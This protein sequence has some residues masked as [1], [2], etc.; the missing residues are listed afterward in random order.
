MTEF[1]TGDE[2][3]ISKEQNVSHLLGKDGP[4]IFDSYLNSTALIYVDTFEM[5]PYTLPVSFLRTKEEYEREKENGTI[6]VGSTA[7]INS[8]IP[9][10]E[11]EELY[12]L[13][14]RLYGKHCVI[15]RE[16]LNSNF[17]DDFFVLTEDNEFHY[18]P[19]K[20]L[21][22]IKLGENIVSD[23][24][25]EASD[26]INENRHNLTLDDVKEIVKNRDENAIFNI[27]DL[28]TVV[29]LV[30]FSTYG[31]NDVNDLNDLT[32]K[33]FGE[34]LTVV[35][36]SNS[37]D[38]EVSVSSVDGK[39]YN[40]PKKYIAHVAK[41]EQDTSKVINEEDSIET[42]STIK[43]DDIVYLSENI[44][45]IKSFVAQATVNAC[46]NKAL[47]VKKLPCEEND[48]MYNVKVGEM[49][50]N[51]KPIFITKENPNSKAVEQNVEYT[52]VP[53]SEVILVTVDGKEGFLIKK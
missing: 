1:N 15:V 33:L 27:G 5:E 19:K 30:P 53:K 22:G 24:A 18:I 37:G 25:K 42:V 52:F 29:E 45:N 26:G 3:W 47:I 23:E 39:I 46:G 21:V 6:H 49:Y 34:F 31:S 36:N 14:A 40:I 44:K 32:I 48:Y 11:N 17:I 20:V 51:I 28:V 43:V 9:K 16:G 10:K 13:T 4:F 2:V 12:K 41:P 7:K 8:I 38:G 50:V 35:P